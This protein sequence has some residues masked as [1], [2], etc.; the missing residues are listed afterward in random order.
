MR[1]VVVVFAV[2]VVGVALLIGGCPAPSATDSN[3][4]ASPNANVAP[5]VVA[6]ENA[7]GTSVFV[8]DSP[9]PDPSGETPSGG[10]NANSNGG[11][12]NANANSNDNGNANVNADNANANQNV[13]G[14]GNGNANANANTNGSSASPLA[15]R[16][17]ATLSCTSTQS[18]SGV[19]TAPNAENVAIEIT[20]DVNGQLE[21]LTVV[22]FANGVDQV[23]TM[24][25]VGD[26]DTLT[27]DT[28]GLDANLVVTL[29]Q[30]RYDGGGVQ[31]TVGIN[32][33]GQQG[34]LIQ[35]GSGSQVLAVSPSGAALAYSL[36]VT[37][38]VNQQSGSLVLQ[39]GEVIE[40]DGTLSLVP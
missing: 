2:A 39:T 22:N 38:N 15:G 3:A 31:V 21:S 19:P 36:D 27:A 37:Y 4:N 40:C 11:S 34:A 7:N 1:T 20:F 17:A 26:T 23:A 35:V 29:Q 10:A 8:G 24:T 32:Y 6:N 33:T 9:S 30:V 18:L 28:G 13:N 14:G 16:W 25:I 12:T 5:D